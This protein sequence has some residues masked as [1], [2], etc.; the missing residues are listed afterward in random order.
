MLVSFSTLCWFVV[1]VV[2]ACLM[3]LF[4]SGAFGGLT[5][6]VLDRVGVGSSPF[7][8]VSFSVFFRGFGGLLGRGCCPCVGPCFGPVLCG[9]FCCCGR[10]VFAFWCP[11]P[12]LVCSGFVRRAW[13]VVVSVLCAFLF[14]WFFFFLVLCLAGF[15]LGVVFLFG[16]VGLFL[17]LVLFPFFSGCGSFGPFLQFV[18]LC[19]ASCLCRLWAFWVPAFF[20]AL[21]GWVRFFAALFGSGSFFFPGWAGLG[22]C[23]GVR[24]LAVF[25]LCFFLPSL[26]CLWGWEWAFWFFRRAFC[27][28]LLSCVGF[29]AP[30]GWWFAAFVVFACLCRFGL[31]WGRLCGR[32]WFCVFFG[33]LGGFLCLFSF[34]LFL[35]CGL[36]WVSGFFCC[37]LFRWCC[38]LGVL[39]CAVD[40]W[41]LGVFCCFWLVSFFSFLPRGRFLLWPLRF[42]GV[43]FGCVVFVAFRFFVGVV[44]RVVGGCLVGGL[45]AFLSLA[46]CWCALWGLFFLSVALYFLG[47]CSLFW[48]FVCGLW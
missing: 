42:G 11:G 25:L 22:L 28:L 17:C 26:W 27:L 12:W 36:V 10:V 31:L 8:G 38:C 1:F 40:I 41:G 14:V 21:G 24:C 47:L 34:G 46:V 43:V 5:C 29:V 7:G 32:V 18:A 20:F 2:L 13:G 44:V 15:S 9:C 30:F 37:W 19:V 3:C 39:G 35:P 48:L 4:F 33:V 45:V 23:F 6:L 16:P